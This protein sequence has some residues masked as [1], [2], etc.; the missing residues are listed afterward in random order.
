[1]ELPHDAAIL[2]LSIYPKGLKSVYHKD[3]FTP[4]F[5]AVLDIKPRLQN[6][7]KC[8]STEEWIKNM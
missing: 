1:M 4:I 8:S 7:R 5:I 3:V 2:L 6:Q